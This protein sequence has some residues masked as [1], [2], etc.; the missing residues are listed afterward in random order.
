MVLYYNSINWSNQYSEYR[1]HV[2]TVITKMERFAITM[3]VQ[4]L[5]QDV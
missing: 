1:N 2:T 3:A 4:P 5:K